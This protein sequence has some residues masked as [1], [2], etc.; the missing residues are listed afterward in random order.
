MLEAMILTMIKYIQIK[1]PINKIFIGIA[2]NWRYE[3][4][5]IIPKICVGKCIYQYMRICISVSVCM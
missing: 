1:E 3:C 4:E 5:L 2:W